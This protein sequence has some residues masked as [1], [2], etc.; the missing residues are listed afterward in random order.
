MFME[1]C[2]ALV[3]FVAKDNGQPKMGVLVPL[4]DEESVVSILQY[5]DVKYIC[6]A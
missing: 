3:R 6:F 2:Y 5:F 1:N 4:L